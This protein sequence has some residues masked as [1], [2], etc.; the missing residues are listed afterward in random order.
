LRALARTT[1]LI[2][3]EKHDVAVPHVDR[4]D[5]CGLIA[6]A[7]QTFKEAVQ[8]RARQQDAN[9]ASAAERTRL[10]DQREDL[11]REFRG[12]VQSLSD[13]LKAGSVGLDEAG[14]RLSQSVTAT[15]RMAT[16]AKASAS[17]T[18]AGIGTVAG[19]SD[20]MS[21]SI[22]EIAARAEEAARVAS[23]A[24]ATGEASKDGVADLRRGA[25]KIGE[26][27]NVIRTIAAQT[28]L[29]ALNATIE[30]ARAGE[31]GRG[32]AV[33]AAEVKALASQTSVATEEISDQVA[34]IQLASGDVVTAFEAVL[35]ALADVDSVAASIA[36]AVE[37]QGIA[38]GEIARSAGQAAEGAEEMNQL[39]DSLE[40]T[41]G[42]ASVAVRS[43]ET[44]AA[45]FRSGADELV[46]A[47]DGFLAKVAA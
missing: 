41:A 16:G 14:A 7:L 25:E 27:V 43:L 33:V 5:E 13:G 23:G 17:Q 47:V 32:F 15:A 45:S 31:S 21:S 6:R 36:S 34:Q 38:T 26:V 42:S 46:T 24:V 20:Q 4:Q 1:E 39:V 19:A 8:E 30:A 10:A 40:E 37:E 2:A 28:N 9:A 11:I 3:A 18:S 29:L 35:T 22:R 44:T 12:T